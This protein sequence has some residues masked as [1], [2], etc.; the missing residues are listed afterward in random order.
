LI[1][2]HSVHVLV[3]QSQFPYYLHLIFIFPHPRILFESSC[4]FR[5]GLLTLYYRYSGFVIHP[6]SSFWAYAPPFFGFMYPQIHSGLRTLLLFL[7]FTHPWVYAPIYYFLGLRTPFF[8]GFTH[9]WVYAPIFSFF[10]F[11]HPFF[12][13]VYAPA[14][15]THPFIYF[16][17]LA[18][19]FSLG[20]RP[21]G[22]T[23]PFI[24]FWVYAPILSVGLRTRWVY[25][26]IYLFL[27]FSTRFF[28]GYTHPLG[29]CTRYLIYLYLY[30]WLMHPYSPG[31]S[32]IYRHN[33]K[34]LSIPPEHANNTAARSL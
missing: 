20:L 15:F 10:G 33:M 17:G 9:P 23:H 6:L 3:S 21:P 8:F 25:T 31:P 26:P 29:L 32:R 11:T 16:L 34:T 27:G 13:W 18:P 4:Y 14:G 28:F 5:L 7:G 1:I 30:F 12:L 22:F 24:H 2:D 19:V